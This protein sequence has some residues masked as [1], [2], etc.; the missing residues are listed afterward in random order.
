MFLYMLSKFEIIWMRIGQIIRFEIIYKF[1]WNPLWDK[2]KWSRQFYLTVNS[3]VDFK[4]QRQVM[5]LLVF[6]A[7]YGKILLTCYGTGTE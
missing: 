4:C 5:N 2:K 1:F 7:I 3:N 6:K